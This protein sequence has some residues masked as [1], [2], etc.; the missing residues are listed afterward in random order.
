MLD[1]YRT[2]VRRPRGTALLISAVGARLP[3]GM[4]GLA[5][6]LLVNG[7]YNVTTAGVAIACYSIGLGLLAPLRGRLID[8]LGIP[9]TIRVTTVVYGLL[10]GGLVAASVVHAGRPLVFSLAAGIGLSAPPLGPSVRAMWASAPDSQQRRAGLAVDAI[11]VDLSFILGPLTVS[12]LVTVSPAA[13]MLGLLGVTVV[14]ALCLVFTARGIGH[15]P[16]SPATGG[17]RRGRDLLG[18]L[19]RAAFRRLQPVVIFVNAAVTGTMV[20]LPSLANLDRARWATGLLVALV[21]AGSITGA[22]LWGRRRKQEGRERPEADRLPRLLFIFTLSLTL[23]PLAAS[24]LALLLAAAPV[25]GLP[26]ASSMASMAAVA[27]ESAP[28]GMAAEAQSWV[29]SFNQVGSAA[30]A[31]IV[32]YLTAHV[33][34]HIALATPCVFALIAAVLAV[35]QRR[36]SRKSISPA[37][38][39]AVAA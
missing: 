26:I 22:L 36:I 12:A 3:Q 18:P 2:L 31:A 32:A 38:E 24:H 17:S 29:V 28:P 35:M 21:S 13:G 14:G 6:L 10:I 19:R 7:Y 37:V 11:F 4:V 33:S 16:R 23:L 39:S 20:G 1:E 27:H 5:L 30:S 34:A 9:S 15:V 8:R 25:A